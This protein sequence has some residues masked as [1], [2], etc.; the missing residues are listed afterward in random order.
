MYPAPQLLNANIYR[1]VS[2]HRIYWTTSGVEEH[3]ESKLDGDLR[4]P[5]ARRGTG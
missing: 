4:I 5:V 1:A 3:A 2:F